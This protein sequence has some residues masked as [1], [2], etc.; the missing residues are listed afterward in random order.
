[1]QNKVSELQN[2]L[3]VG[4]I[5]VYFLSFLNSKWKLFYNQLARSPVFPYLVFCNTKNLNIFVLIYSAE[6]KSEADKKA[7]FLGYSTTSQIAN[8]Y[9]VLDTFSIDPMRGLILKARFF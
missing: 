8:F 3:C 2:Q 5:Y 9:Q 6:T 1:M 4:K 7:E